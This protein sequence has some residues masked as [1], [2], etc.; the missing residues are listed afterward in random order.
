MARMKIMTTGHQNTRAKPSIFAFCAP[1]TC[2]R[3]PLDVRTYLPCSTWNVVRTTIAPHMKKRKGLLPPASFPCIQLLLKPG[4]LN[5]PLIQHRVGDLQEARDIGAVHQVAGRAVLLGRFVAVLVDGDHDLVQTIVDFFT[6]PGDAHTVLRHFQSGSG[7]A[8]GIGGL[9]RSVEDFGVEE[10]LGGFEGARHISSLADNLHAV[11]D[12]VRRVFRVDLILSGA[13]EGAV[14]LDVP[15]PVVVELLVGGAVDGLL[16]FAGVLLDA[17]AAVILQLHD[18]GEL[19]A[20]DAVGVVDGAVGIR[21]GNRLRAQIKQ[22]LDGVLRDVAAAGDQTY[23]AFQRVFA[24]LQHFVG[25][26]HAAIAGGLGTNQRTAPSQAFAGKD[27]GEFIP[28][29]LILAKHEA[30]F[31]SAHADV[32][33]GNV[34]V[35]ADVTAELGHEALAEAHYFVVALALGVEIRTALAAAHGQRGERILEDLF[36]R[37]EFQNAEIHRGMEAQSAL[38]GADGAVHLDAEAAINLHFALVVEPGH[39]EHQDSFG[40]R[41]TL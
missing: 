5:Q 14:G 34:R 41:N 18:K 20:V 32:A 10:R 12:E 27:A 21:Q 24:S 23:F 13:R 11:L 33:G 9:G 35:R 30:D 16:E 2:P 28:Q 15:Q 29:A 6:S 40:L 37:Q 22:L 7:N 31:A 19:V 3:R 25:E 1:K 8:A 39:A 38:V 17:A 36:E 26:V 4:S